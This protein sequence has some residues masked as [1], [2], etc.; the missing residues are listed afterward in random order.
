RLCSETLYFSQHNL[1]ATHL[2]FTRRYLYPCLPAA[3]LRG[4][5]P[6]CVHTHALLRARLLRMGIF[7][8][9]CAGPLPL[10][11]DGESMVRLLWRILY[12]L[13]G[14]HERLTLVD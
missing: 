13:P 7:P 1:R 12:A 11:L 4:N 10:G 3:F 6:E 8:V 5:L 9:G 14:L 2:L